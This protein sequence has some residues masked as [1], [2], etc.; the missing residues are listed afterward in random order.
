MKTSIKRHRTV[1]LS[2]GAALLAATLVVPQKAHADAATATALGGA[3]LL[4]TLLHSSHHYPAHYGH[5][6]A[7]PPAYVYPA[8]VVQAPMAVP[9]YPAGPYYYYYP[10]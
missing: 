4:G 1:W 8:P 5:P 2:V 9:V 3:A 10:Y 7:H 6:F